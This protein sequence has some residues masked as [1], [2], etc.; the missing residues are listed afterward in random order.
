MLAAFPK[1]NTLLA[2][3]GDVFKCRQLVE[4]KCT[5]IVEILGFWSAPTL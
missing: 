4:F 5:I 2:D 3:K 1:A